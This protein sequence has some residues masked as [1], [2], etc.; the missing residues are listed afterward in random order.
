VPQVADNIKL[1]DLIDQEITRNEK[2]IDCAYPADLN[3]D[4]SGKEE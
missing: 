2:E 1:V 4:S 3:K